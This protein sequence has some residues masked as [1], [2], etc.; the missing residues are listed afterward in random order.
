MRFDW[1][2]LFDELDHRGRFSGDAHLTD[3][4]GLTRS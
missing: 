1:Y 4:P 3:S 2:E